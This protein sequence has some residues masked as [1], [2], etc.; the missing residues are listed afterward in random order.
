MNTIYSVMNG[1]HHIIIILH[2]DL[3]HIL[4][5]ALQLLHLGEEVTDHGQV[6]AVG[7]ASTLKSESESC[8]DCGQE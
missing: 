5:A 6:V 7:E 3:D 2:M 1:P 4:H 8:I